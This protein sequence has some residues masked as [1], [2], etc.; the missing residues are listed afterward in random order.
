MKCVL[1]KVLLVD[2]MQR[3]VDVHATA[4]K[5]FWMEFCLQHHF[6]Y[7]IRKMFRN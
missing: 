1:E 2:C 7:M 3:F 4:G 5:F 6:V